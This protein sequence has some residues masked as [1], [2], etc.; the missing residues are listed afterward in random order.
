MAIDILSI[1]P[2]SA[3]PECAFSGGRRTLSWDRERMTCENVEK[4]EW[5]IQKAVHSGMGVITDTGFDSGG[6]ED[7]DVNSDRFADT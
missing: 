7:P 3:D 5:H 1:A 4:V 6:D 2:E